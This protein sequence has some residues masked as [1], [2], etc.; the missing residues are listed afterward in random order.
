MTNNEL[1]HNFLAQYRKPYSLDQLSDYLALSIKKLIPLH[2]Q[3]ME[4][5]LLRELEPG[6]FVST[7]AHVV[8]RSVTH[9]SNLWTLRGDI[10][11]LILDEIER[12]RPWSTRALAKTLGYSHQYI[13]QYLSA[14]AAINAIGFTDQGYTVISRAHLDRLG[15]DLRPGLLRE[16][17]AKAGFKGKR[18]AAH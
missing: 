10:A 3:A 13:A 9:R 18:R 16:L 4:Q 1:L 2:A 5:G 7:L 15:C 17:K 12:S 8:G 14:L 11:L 6:I